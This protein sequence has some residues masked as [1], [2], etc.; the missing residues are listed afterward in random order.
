VPP[1]NAVVALDRFNP[2]PYGLVSIKGW[3][4]RPIANLLLE[5]ENTTPAN[6][7][8]SQHDVIAAWLGLLILEVAERSISWQVQRYRI[9]IF[10]EVRSVRCRES[11]RGFVVAC[12]R[13]FARRRRYAGFVL[14]RRQL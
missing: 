3:G 13:G 10:N 2:M 6:H 9:A 4:W 1:V 11:R 8:V 12:G 7:F 14:C 5:P